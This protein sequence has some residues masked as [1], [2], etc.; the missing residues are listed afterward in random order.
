M[1][2]AAP[3]AGSGAPT[4]VARDQAVPVAG[5]PLGTPSVVPV[6]VL[7][8]LALVGLGVVALREV[9]VGRQV[10]GTTLVPGDA[11]LGPLLRS[12][13]SLVQGGSAVLAGVGGLLL[14]VLLVMLAVAARPRP[15][16]RLAARHPMDVPVDVDLRGVAALAADA[17]LVDAEV[18]T[19]RATARP[20][21]VVV[22]VSVDPR[23]SH[24]EAR[25]AAGVT[26]RVAER[27]R[28]LDPSPKVRVRVHGADR[29]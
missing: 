11:W 6:A 12:A 27:L 13:T 23:D 25:L 7:L 10:A 22:D 5:P 20:R 28:D 2:A 15:S 21:R 3:T 19:S 14:G 18:G 1:S 17:A 8:C 29:R 24:D 16:A 4:T 26:E 9:L